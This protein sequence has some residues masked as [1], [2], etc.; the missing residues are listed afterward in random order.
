MKI[1]I[2]E[3]ELICR[4]MLDDLLQGWGHEVIAVADGISAWEML[5][6]AEAPPVAILD[7][8]M[9][10]LDGVEVCRR[11]RQQ[12]TMTPPYL[13]LLTSRQD[14]ASVVTGLRC[15]A[16]DY[17]SKPCDPEEL[18]ARIDV[19]IRMV[20]LQRSLNERIRELEGALAHIKQLQDILPICM[21]CKKVRNDQNYWQQVDVY[22][23]EHTDMLLSHG[24][25]PE[26][27]PKIMEQTRQ[28]LDNIKKA[29]SAD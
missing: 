24:I 8:Q 27:L 3:D 5:L 16:D 4:T 9:P 29:A 20:T 2:A 12:P 15:G 17:V 23:I 26:C 6:S 22:L 25:C 14:T 28:K 18:R 13:L 21:Y 1:L 7:W 19:G 10:G 11:V